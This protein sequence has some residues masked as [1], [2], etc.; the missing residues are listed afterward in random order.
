MLDAGAD[1]AAEALVER[2]RVRIV[3]MLRRA[4]GNAAEPRRQVA[5]Q[6]MDAR[7]NAG[8][9]QR[10]GRRMRIG[11]QLVAEVGDEDDRSDPREQ[12][13]DRHDL[14]NRPRVFAGAGPG[15]GNRQESGRRD[16]GAGQHRKGGRGVGVGCR[17]DPV[18]ALFHLDRHHLDGDDRVIDEQAEA[19]HERTKRDLVQAD[20]EVVHRGEGHGQDQRDRHGDDET[21]AQAQRKEADQQD[22][23]HGLAEGTH[24]LAY[25]AAHRGRLVGNLVQVETDRQGPADACGRRLEVVAERDDVAALAHRD[26]DA[27]C[28]GALEAHARLRRID[29]T[30][31]DLGD[32]AEPEQAA[33]AAADAEVAD[34]LDRIECAARAQVDAVGR[35]LEAATRNHRV[36]RGQGLLQLGEADPELGQLGIRGLDEDLRVLA[37]DQFDLGDVRHAQQFELDP[38]GV[39]AQVGVVETVAG[40]RVDVAEGVAEFVVEERAADVGG[41]GVADVPDLLSHLVPDVR[42]Q[43]RIDRILDHEEHLRFARARIAAQV[44]ELRYLLQ[45]LLDRLGDLFRD[46]ARRGAGPLGLH[47]HDLECERRVLG[48]AEAAV[49]PDADDREQDDRVEHEGLVAQCPRGKIE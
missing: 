25:R 6:G 2:A 34:R 12:Q 5:A 16:Q 32:V 45:L 9:R 44:I 33:V 21:A 42:D 36:L 39:V 35:G 27:D 20:A 37:A 10:A 43:G 48:L 30:A 46:L 7:A 19:E 13:G 14:E 28:L 3:C 8:S 31:A 4:L 38:F 26:G 49:G 41:Q 29:E 40:Q 11:Q 23:R 22:D 24:E 47:D 1:E 18:H 17:A 15:R